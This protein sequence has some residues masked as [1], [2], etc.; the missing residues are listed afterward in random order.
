MPQQLTVGVTDL[1]FHR[2]TASLVTHVLRGMGFDVDRVFSHHE[3]NFEKLQSGDIDMLVS[4][5]LPSSHG[6]YKDDV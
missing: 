2:L 1:S 4:A 6:G 5:W 3:S